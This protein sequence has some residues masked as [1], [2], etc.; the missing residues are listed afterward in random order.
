MA[1][2]VR[3]QPLTSEARVRTLVSGISGG[4]SGTGTGFSPRYP[5][6]NMIPPGLHTH[7]A[8]SHIYA[9]TNT[10]IHTHTVCILTK[11]LC[12]GHCFHL[13]NNKKLV[14]W[15]RLNTGGRDPA[16]PRCTSSLLSLCT[17]HTS[18]RKPE[19][20]YCR[21]EVPLLRPTNRPISRH[22]RTNECLI[23][24]SLTPLRHFVTSVPLPRN[25]PSSNPSQ[26]GNRAAL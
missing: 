6:V 4:Q 10:Y 24:A 26:N 25:P 1:Q 9:H 21:P 19:S 14:N 20:E 22:Y 23:S 18:D 16:F 15:R 7:I 13:A 11:V 5:P 17:N 8:H 3:R 12:G 2:A